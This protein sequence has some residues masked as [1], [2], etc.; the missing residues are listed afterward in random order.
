MAQDGLFFRSL[1]KIH[2]VH[3][4]PTACIVAQGVWSI[5]LTFSG[6]YEQL[7]TYAIFAVFLFHT[8]T[9]AALFVLRWRRPNWPRTYRAWGYPWTSIVFILT[10]LAFVTNT[11]VV[12]P[13][14]SLWGLLLMALG[15]PAYLWWRRSSATRIRPEPPGKRIQPSRLSA[16]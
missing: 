8:A 6:S 7:G 3:R 10:S 11:L 16:E 12:R 14:E 5:V 1:A 2:P 15:L 4:T 13:I 9:G